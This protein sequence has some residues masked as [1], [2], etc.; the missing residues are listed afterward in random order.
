MPDVDIGSLPGSADYKLTDFERLQFLQLPWRA[1][2]DFQ[3]PFTL[4]KDRG[5]SYYKYLGP[6]H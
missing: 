2:A 1:P 5:R 3:W 4:R 6:Q